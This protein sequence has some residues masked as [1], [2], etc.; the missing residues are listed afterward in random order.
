M[1][2]WCLAPPRLALLLSSLSPSPPP[3]LQIANMKKGVVSALQT[4]IAA[5]LDIET[6]A[7]GAD[8][9]Y[10]H[11][12]R[13]ESGHYTG[14]FEVRRLESGASTLVVEGGADGS[15]AAASPMLVR[16]TKRRT[17]E[18]YTEYAGGDAPEGA[19]AVEHRHEV[20]MFAHNGTV[21][22]VHVAASAGL[23]VR[24]DLPPEVYHDT[25][26]WQAHATRHVTGSLHLL[27]AE[28]VDVVA[29]YG[30]DREAS[31]EHHR[32]H[33]EG[34]VEDSLVASTNIDELI[35]GVSASANTQ[36][37]APHNTTQAAR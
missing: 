23:V 20:D 1:F 25:G 16:I 30:D 10:S 11:P 21:K 6:L 19:M 36:L 27:H 37:Q 14:H 2:R 31:V 35:V 17:H 12:Q 28:S 4:H 22:H 26:V 34:L 32:R 24:D 15:T 5:D 13:D 18:D 8:E 7:T 3:P 9:V 29:P 33:L